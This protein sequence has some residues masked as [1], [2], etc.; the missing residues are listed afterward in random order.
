[1][2]YK[3]IIEKHSTEEFTDRDYVGKEDPKA[4]EYGYTYFKNTRSKTEE[5]YSQQTDGEIDL[6]AIIDAF[7]K[8]EENTPKQ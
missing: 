3:I 4:D 6:K 2:K 7:N 5:V 1:M 8:T